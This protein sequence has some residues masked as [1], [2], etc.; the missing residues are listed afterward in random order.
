MGVLTLSSSPRETTVEKPPRGA[1]TVLGGR[2]SVPSSST[3]EPPYPHSQLRARKRKRP[4]ITRMHQ[5]ASQWIRGSGVPPVL[6]V[7]GVGNE[8]GSTVTHFLSVLRAERNPVRMR[9][10]L[11]TDDFVRTHALEIR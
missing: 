4:A 9:I 6:V 8:W 11:C 2:S 10:G 1:S 7:R 5:A 3:G